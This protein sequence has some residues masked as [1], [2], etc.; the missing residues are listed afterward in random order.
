MRAEFQQIMPEHALNLRVEIRH[1]C[2][3]KDINQS[4]PSLTLEN[5]EHLEA[6]LIVGADGVRFEPLYSVRTLPPDLRIAPTFARWMGNVCAL[7]LSLP[8]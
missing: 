5:G 8:V 4:E 1:G 2:R 3:I 6:D 7:I